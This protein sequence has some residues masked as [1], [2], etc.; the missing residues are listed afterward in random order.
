MKRVCLMAAVGSVDG[1]KWCSRSSNG[2]QMSRTELGAVALDAP[3]KVVR[4][5]G[6]VLT[7]QAG[8]LPVSHPLRRAPPSISKACSYD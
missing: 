5:I 1:A 2:R 4:T 7:G 3:P 8:K 6:Y